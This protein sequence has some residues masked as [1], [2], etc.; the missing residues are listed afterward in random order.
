MD[1]SKRR[2][3]LIAKFGSEEALK[4]H[5]REMQRKSREK[6]K[7]TGGFAHLKKHNPKLFKEITSKGGAKRGKNKRSGNDEAVV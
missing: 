4:E 3:T 1:Y 2:Q 7:G 5:Y 6:Y